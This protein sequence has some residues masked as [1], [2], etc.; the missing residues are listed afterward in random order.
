M[1]VRAEC[2]QWIYLDCLA[3][4]AT[5]TSSIGHGISLLDANVHLTI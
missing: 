5:V 4:A 3:T 2:L 1:H